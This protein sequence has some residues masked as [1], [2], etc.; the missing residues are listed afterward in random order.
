MTSD[1]AFPEIKGAIHALGSRF[2][3]VLDDIVRRITSREPMIGS[4]HALLGGLTDVRHYSLLKSILDLKRNAHWVCRGSAILGLSSLAAE[5]SQSLDDFI[6]L[7]EHGQTRIK[8]YLSDPE[9][10]EY[11]FK[12]SGGWDQIPGFLR[13]IDKTREGSSAQKLV[14]RILQDFLSRNTRIMYGE[15]EYA[16]AKSA[17]FRLLE[18]LQGPGRAARLAFYALGRMASVQDIPRIEQLGRKL[19]LEDDAGVAITIVRKYERP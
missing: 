12:E 5:D 3:E 16:R 7:L 4:V 10:V 18:E 11:T 17:T 14:T 19:G 9:L 8:I 15:P 13:V 1:P 6:D 2:P